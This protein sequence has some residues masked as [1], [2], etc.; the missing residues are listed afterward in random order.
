MATLRFRPLSALLLRHVIVAAALV[1]LLAAGLQGFLAFREENGSFHSVVQ[2]IGL[3]S[4][5]LLSV[6][7]RDRDPD[8]IDRQLALIVSRPEIAYVRLETGEGRVF[9]AGAAGLREFDGPYHLDVLATE[10]KGA[11]ATLEISADRQALVNRVAEK[12][13][14]V[15][16]GDLAL[17]IVICA[18]VA[19][20]LRMELEEPMRRLARFTTELTPARLTTPLELARGKRRWM[21]EID[22]VAQGFTTLQ[23][24]IHSHVAG[25][26]QQVTQRTAELQHA[27]DEIRALT[28]LD[29]L[30]GCY[31][32]RHL[33]ERLAAEV[34][35]SH[36]TGQPLAVIVTDLDHFKSIND[37]LGHAAGDE[38]LRELAK[39]YQAGL[40]A[41]LD[42]LARIGGEEFVVVLPDA[43]LDVASTV[44]ERL[45]IAIECAVL[46]HGGET[47]RASAS[48][49]VSMCRAGDSAASVIARADAALYDAKSRGRNR[50]LAG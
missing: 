8:A 41:N 4:V 14:T 32:R 18:L 7:L 6:G 40:R 45:R 31:N 29:P 24:A 39:V 22:L 38:V 11:V 34:Q 12:V 5:P 9:Q 3:T 19:A 10:G 36:R 26:D 13:I 30:T 50:V 49:G 37:R 44:A 17:S 2:G 28:L 23:N 1:T 35:R 20:V 15:I 16:A 48:F 27:L 46:A 43:N 33:D 21:D 42:W 47:I 25:L